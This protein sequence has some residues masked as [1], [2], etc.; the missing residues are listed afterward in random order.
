MIL[1]LSIESLVENIF[2][3]KNI[4][5][6]IFSKLIFIISVENKNVADILIFVYP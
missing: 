2:Q 4:K 3:S 6:G 1:M 5:Y